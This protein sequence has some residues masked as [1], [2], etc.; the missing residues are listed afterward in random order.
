MKIIVNCVQNHCKNYNCR[1]PWQWKPADEDI[2]NFNALAQN[3]KLIVPPILTKLILDREP[4]KVQLWVDKVCKKFDFTHVISSHVN[5]YVQASPKD[6]KDAFEVLSVENRNL[7]PQ[8]RR[9]LAEDLALLQK[10]SD[11][12]T[13]LNVVD[14][15]KVCDGEPA[16]FVGRFAN[17][18]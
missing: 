18:K 8:S 4:E 14:V 3:G 1:Y 6:F 10:A 13:Q 2:K 7:V 12:L 9:P 11:L 15:S 5:N 17:T 16:R